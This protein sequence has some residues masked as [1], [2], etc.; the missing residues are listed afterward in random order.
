VPGSEHVSPVCAGASYPQ[1]V[2][3]AAGSLPPT[4]TAED[5]ATDEAPEPAMSTPEMDDEKELLPT[6]VN[7]GGDTA[8]QKVA[9]KQGKLLHCL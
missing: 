2:S 9:N 4:D 6:D 3:A 8:E 7:S 1:S 5:R